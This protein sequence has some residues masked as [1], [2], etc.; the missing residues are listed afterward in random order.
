M[1]AITRGHDWTQ[2]SLGEPNSWPQ[3]LKTTLSLLLNSKFPMFLLWGPDYLCFYNDAFRPSLGN[4]GKH[5][6]VGKKG[7]E[8]WAEIWDFIGPLMEQVLATGEAVWFEDQLVPFYRNGKMEDIYW[9]FSYSPVKDEEGKNIA[10]FVT[11]NETTDKVLAKGEIEERERNLR[12]IIHQAHVAIAIFRGPEYVVEIVNKQALEL[13][14]RTEQEVLNKPIL[15]IMTELESQGIKQLLD[16]VYSTGEPF[17]ATEL[18]VQLLRNGKTETAYINF[19]YEALYNAA[20][21]ING[22]ITIGL[23]VTTSVNARKAIEDSEALFR[24]TVQQAPVPIG[25]L[26]G[27][28]LIFESANDEMLKLIGKNAGIIG[29]PFIDALPEMTGQPYPKIL[30]DVFWSGKRYVELEAKALLNRNGVTMEGYYNYV[31]QPIVDDEGK[32]SRIMLVA[33]EVTE[34]VLANK[35]IQKLNE[36][37]AAANEELLT[38]NEEMNATNEELSEAQKILQTLNASLIENEG[39]FRSLVKQAP[40]GI[41]IIRASNLVVLIVNDAYLGLAG[42]TAEQLENQYIWDAVPEAARVYG[43]IMNEVIAT[44]TAYYGK[45]VELVLVRHGTPENVVLDFVYEPILDSQGNVDLVMVIAI[46]VTEKVNARRRIEEMEERTRLATEAAETGTFDLDLKKQEML[47]SPRF[48]N[49]FGFDRHVSWETFASVIHPD[50]KAIRAA[51]H[52]KAL[53]TGKLFYEARV[54]YADGSIHWIRV[55]GQLYYDKDKLP[56]RILGT[57]L[58]I[59]QFKHL[60][61]QKDDFLS[62]ASHELKTPITSLK[63]SLQLLDRMKNDPQPELLRKLIVQ[64]NKSMQKI[65]ALVEDLLNVS[66]ASESHLK[67]NKTS[68]NVANMLNNCCGD[69]RFAGKHRL[70][71]EGDL[72]LEIKADEHAIDQVIVNLVNNAVK[73]AP[74]SLEIV[75]AISTEDGMAK[76]AV[77]DTG[78]GIAPDKVAHIFERY[79]QADASGYQ[80]SGLGLGLYISSEIIK[81]HGGQIGVESVLGLG[82]TFWIKLPLD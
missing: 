5:P 44:G 71:I 53:K 23:D 49:I 37:L 76:I 8:V 6:A 27:S 63:A 45:E 33:V 39:M 31:Y 77:K 60:Q 68:F 78:P 22:L 34:Q 20:G 42:K 61:Q 12:L 81:R 73:Y 80:R 72:E 75:L 62:I 41:C 1:G 28:D 35:K 11:C 64:S 67:I 55:Q 24:R 74:D 13:W 57:L 50:D 59:T 15:E 26:K 51:A 32:T 79:Y 30:S 69:V 19:V 38:A 3:S 52:E 82:S 70:I 9:T 17:S 29:L 25:V 54:I 7:Q 36:D 40:M 58:D 66:R 21:E 48:N 4:E 46:D 56:A 16:H 2:T 43:P 14:G 18:P 47:T 10:I 65:S